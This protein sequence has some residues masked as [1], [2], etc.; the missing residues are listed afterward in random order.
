[1]LRTFC[2]C[3]PSKKKGGPLCPH[4]KKKKK[5]KKPLKKKDT[6]SHQNFTGSYEKYGGTIWALRSMEY[7][8]DYSKGK[9]GK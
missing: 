5:K 8:N 9:K 1:M 7:Q 2:N 6:E 3:K 4:K